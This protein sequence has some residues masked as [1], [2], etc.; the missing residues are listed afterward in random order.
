MRYLQGRSL[1]EISEQLSRTP[2]AV[3]GLLKRGLEAL[4]GPPAGLRVTHADEPSRRDVREPRVDA[5][6]AAYLE[7]E[8]AGHAPDRREFLA[9]HPDLAAELEAFFT[10]HDTVAPG[11]RSPRGGRGHRHAR[12]VAARGEAATDADALDGCP[13]RTAGPVHGPSPG[14]ARSATTS[15]WRRSAGAAWA[16]STRPGSAGLNRVV[17]L[18][19]I[20]GGP[21]LARPTSSG[22]ASRPR[23]WPSSTTRTSCRSTRSASTRGTGSSA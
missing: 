17:A 2:D 15:C 7:A 4:R 22:S 12:P 13:T 3:G 11:R 18:K 14:S 21:G 9:R 10:D 1:A 20:L 6:I 23:R 8:D 16:S 5:A 19:M